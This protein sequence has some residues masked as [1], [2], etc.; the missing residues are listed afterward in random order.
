MNELELLNLLMTTEHNLQSAK[1]D[2][3]FANDAQSKQ[4]AYRTQ[5]E[6]ENKID[7]ITTELIDIADKNHSEEA[8]YSVINQLN[9]YV[10]QINMVRHGARLTRNQ[11]MI[12]ENMLFGNI[13]MD[14]NNV[15]L[16]GGQGGHIPA[17]LEYTLSEKNSISIAELTAFFKN[18]ILIV[19]SIEKPNFIK[20]RDYYNGFRIRIQSQFMNE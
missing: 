2:V 19:Q 10:E 5:K 14:I 8:K 4:I 9:H 3:Q 12:L 20:L 15:I 17:Y 13:S 16:R 7:L 1:M 6:I 18:E 11:G